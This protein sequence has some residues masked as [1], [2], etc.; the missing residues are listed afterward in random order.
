MAAFTPYFFRGPIF[1]VQRIQNL[2]FLVTA[3]RNCANVNAVG[4]AL[5]GLAI[6]APYRII[7]YLVN[8]PGTVSG[9]ARVMLVFY[10]GG[11]H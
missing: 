1:N 4:S 3:P 7:K 8:L 6:Q 11:Y 2:E 9:L 5:S 10:L